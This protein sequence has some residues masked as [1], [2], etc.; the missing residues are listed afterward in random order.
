MDK[1]KLLAL[2]KME[3]T[4]KFNSLIINC[5]KES[6]YGYVAGAYC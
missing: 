1:S 3:I 2:P 4:I 6:R 5:T